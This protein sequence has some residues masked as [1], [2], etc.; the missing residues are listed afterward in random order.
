LKEA[1]TALDNRLKKNENLNESIILEMI[2]SKAGK[3]M[4]RFIASEVISVVVMLLVVPVFIFVLYRDGGKYLVTDILM[5]IAIAICS[6]YPFWGAF[7]L[8]GLLK[9]DLSQSVSNNVYYVNRYNVQIKREHKIFQNFM[10]PILVV[11]VMFSYADR[12][13]TLPWWALCTSA[14]VATT[15]LMFWTNKIY[16][17]NIDSVLRSLDEI[18]ELKEEF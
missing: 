14:L 4:N 9:F 1:W 18:R 7:K 17:K 10:W 6:F 15:L 5:Y 16:H 3:L 11:L 8:H 2:K 13:A 12:N